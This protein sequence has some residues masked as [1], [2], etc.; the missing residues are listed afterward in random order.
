MMGNTINKDNILAVL[1]Y[2]MNKV[3]SGMDIYKLYIFN[4]ICYMLHNTL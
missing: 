2:Y 1:D 4:K 3:Y